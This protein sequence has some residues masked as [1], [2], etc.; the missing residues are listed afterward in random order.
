MGQTMRVVLGRLPQ[1][2]A[3]ALFSADNTTSPAG[4]LLLE[5]GVIGLAGCWISTSPDV[6]I[7]I[8]GAANSATLTYPVPA[9]PALIG[10]IYYQ[11]AIVPDPQSVVGF[12]MSDAATAVVAS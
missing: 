11:Q 8:P 5:L 3:I 2:Q 1:S 10:S 4:P 9:L 6:V 12:V 7:P